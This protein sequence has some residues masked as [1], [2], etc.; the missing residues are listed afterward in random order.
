[1]GDVVL[2]ANPSPDGLHRFIL[3][4]VTNIDEHNNCCGHQLCQSHPT[5]PSSDTDL[6]LQATDGTTAGTLVRPYSP[7]NIANQHIAIVHPRWKTLWV[8][9]TNL[10]PRSPDASWR[11]P[12]TQPTTKHDPIQNL[13]QLPDTIFWHASR[14]V[15]LPASYTYLRNQCI[16]TVW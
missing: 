16:F 9:L 13:I 10:Q 12:T 3:A 11:L 1:M 4:S 8:P 2:L 14:S 5:D 15:R 6:L 7:R